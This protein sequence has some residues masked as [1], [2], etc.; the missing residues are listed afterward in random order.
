[1]QYIHIRSLE[2][3]HPGYKDR[4]LQW[5]KIHFK[6]VQG[7]PD[8]EMITNEIDWGRL[9]KL[10]ILE[11]E[12]QTPIPLDNVYLTRKGFDIE[13]R[14]MSLTIQVLHNF[15]EL[16]TETPRRVDK[17]KEED[18]DK[19]K[20]KKA[21]ATS[22]IEHEFLINSKFKEAWDGWLEVRKKLKTPNTDRALK[23]ALNILEK[24]GIDKAIASLEQSTTR[25]WKGV[26]EPKDYKAPKKHIESAPIPTRPAVD[27]EGL[28]KIRTLVKSVTDKC[29]KTEA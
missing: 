26:F 18:K 2:K 29:G 15:I 16:V 12:A 11:L 24:M 4:T 1:M 13:K 22:I 17:D 25:G 3:Y 8:C 9:I 6:M 27:P 21:C 10:I 7:D 28:K 14:P 23:L 19:E 20:S 5:A